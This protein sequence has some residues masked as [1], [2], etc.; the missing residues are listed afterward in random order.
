MVEFCSKCGA[1]VLGKKGE[2]VDC[3]SCGTK[4]KAKTT[5]SLSEKVE[6]TEEVEIVDSQNSDAVYPV[7]DTITCPKCSNRGAYYW[8][9]QT[10]AG[11]EPETQFFKCVA[12]KHQW[13][14][15]G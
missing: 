6:K 1:I 5:L 11:D 15:Y 7:S 3:P 8:T 4:Q 14:N 13:R 9:K 2:K 12:C 10:R